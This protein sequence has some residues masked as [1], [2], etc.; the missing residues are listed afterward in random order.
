MP[1]TK[2]S[3][4]VTYRVSTNGDITVSVLAYIRRVTTGEMMMNT[5]TIRQQL[6]DQFDTHLDDTLLRNLISEARRTLGYG[7]E[8][9][10]AMLVDF[11]NREGSTARRVAQM[12]TRVTTRSGSCRR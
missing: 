9:E 4:H 6:Q 10:A 2:S 7:T 11:L 12:E 1:I 8:D 5:G 3:Q